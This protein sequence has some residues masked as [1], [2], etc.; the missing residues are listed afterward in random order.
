MP[1]ALGDTSRGA[2]FGAEDRSAGLFLGRMEEIEESA[3]FLPERE[4]KIC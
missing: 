2:S 4:R 3:G 1:W